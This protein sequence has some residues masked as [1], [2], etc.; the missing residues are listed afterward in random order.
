MPTQSL[1]RR[2]VI[3]LLAIVPF[4]APVSADESPARPVKL[5][6]DTDMGNDI[7]DA[8]ALGVTIAS[9]KVARRRTRDCVGMWKLLR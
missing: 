7:D 3:L 5:I 1:V 4:T 9:N 8:L 2:L 6:F